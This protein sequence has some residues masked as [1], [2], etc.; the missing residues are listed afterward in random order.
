MG[1]DPGNTI[2]PTG[3]TPADPPSAF[4]AGDPNGFSAAKP[5]ANAPA[6]AQGTFDHTG[7]TASLSVPLGTPAGANYTGTLQYTV[8]G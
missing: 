5:L 8:T 7:S 4:S 2:A 6:S 1:F 3:P